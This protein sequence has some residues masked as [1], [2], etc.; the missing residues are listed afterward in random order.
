MRRGWAW[1]TALVFLCSLLATTATA[2]APAAVGDGS[3]GVSGGTI[4]FT[5]RVEADGSGSLDV[6]D[7]RDGFH[8]S[9]AQVDLAAVSAGGSVAFRGPGYRVGARDGGAPGDRVD[10]VTIAIDGRDTV[11][12]DPIS[13][14]NVLVKGF[15]P[16]EQ[17][18]SFNPYFG[19]FHNHTAYSDG[20]GFPSDAFAVGK[21]AGLNFLTVSEHSNLLDFPIRFD[22][23]CI[24]EPLEH[25]DCVATPLPELTEWEDVQR[26]AELASDPSI[27]YLGLRGLEWSSTQVGH[28]G[29]YLSSNYPTTSIADT[30]A[31][32][33]DTFWEWFLRDPALDGGADGLGVFNHPSREAHVFEDAS[34]LKTFEDFRYVPEADERMIGV[35]AFNKSDDYSACFVRALHRG[36]HV[37]PIGAQDQHDDWARPGRALTALMVSTDGVFTEATVRESL[38]GRRFYGTKDWN[39]DVAFTID[40]EV[41]GSRL[42]RSAGDPIRLS[43]SVEDPDPG[44]DVARI[45]VFDPSGST[46]VCDR[47][48]RTFGLAPV[49]EDIEEFF[50]IDIPLDAEE[51]PKR[52]TLEESPLVSGTGS[53]LDVVLTPPSGI[54]SWY[55]A[56]IT[57]S[58]GDIV[59]TSPI[60]VAVP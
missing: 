59:Y 15:D 7:D 28:V 11:T 56:R 45:D 36:W 46:P 14:G 48:E 32:T 53:S 41:M 54:E 2:D 18:A 22:D 21:A 23:V 39:V 10:A 47:G 30:F 55:F 37:G 44:D 25:E 5:F 20:E 1:F 33:M 19:S 49:E 8:F 4:T 34:D 38:I 16:V 13:D 52:I 26:Q 6:S 24:T 43:I 60:W 40:G 51:L 17:T 50:G 35:E 57:Q 29:V 9:S 31:L 58:D 12:G 42:D 3:L 27:P